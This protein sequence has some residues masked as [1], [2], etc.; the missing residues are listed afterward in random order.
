MTQ[1]VEGSRQLRVELFKAADGDWWWRLRNA[2][3]GQIVGN[4]EE[5]HRSK[6]YTKRKVR[7]LFPDADI[8]VVDAPD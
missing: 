2:G 4:A 3:N 5:G 6:W 8:A 7:K 1:H